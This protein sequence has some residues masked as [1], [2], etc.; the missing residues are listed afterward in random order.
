MTDIVRIHSDE[1]GRKRISLFLRGQTYYARFH[2]KNRVIS[3]GA[4]YVTETMRTASLEEAAE[5][6]IS[7]YLE[8]LASE[9]SG[10]SIRSTTVADQ[11]DAFVR[12][13]E[14]GLEK[15]LSG[16]S[17]N[18]LRGYRKNICRYWKEY[19]GHKR[20]ADVSLSDLEHYEEWRS[21][22]WDRWVAKQ[23][24]TRVSVAMLMAQF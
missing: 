14:E 24:R 9:K 22:Y 5:R 6:A 8:I 17:K 21:G 20:I 18:M 10:L 13:Y 15:S 1:R 23:D 11:I 2:I 7:R 16:F 4:P 19:V 12:H 3:R